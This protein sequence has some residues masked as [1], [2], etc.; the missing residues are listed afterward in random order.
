MLKLEKCF[1]QD[2]LA[3]HV[4][5]VNRKRKEKLKALKE[6]RLQRQQT[7]QTVGEV[8]RVETSEKY[9]CE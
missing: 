9:C 7:C 2:S 1:C 3:G 5:T 4:A 8:G 6:V